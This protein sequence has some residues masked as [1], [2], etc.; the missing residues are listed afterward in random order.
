MKTK[1]GSLKIQY[2]NHIWIS[3]AE[4]RGTNRYKHLGILQNYIQQ[5]IKRL[6]FSRFALCT[7]R[8]ILYFTW[9]VKNKSLKSVFVCSVF[10]FSSKA[11]YIFFFQAEGGVNK[12]YHVVYHKII[13]ILK[14]RLRCCHFGYL[15]LY[16]ELRS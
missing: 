14:Q 15:M 3:W 5:H 11:I 16:L 7:V 10:S 1:Y 2:F 12:Y 9:R 13:F 4:T 8:A 6:L